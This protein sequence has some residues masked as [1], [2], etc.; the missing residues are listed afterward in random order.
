[1]GTFTKRPDA[2]QGTNERFDAR[3]KERVKSNLPVRLKY[4]MRED[5]RTGYL[6]VTFDEETVAILRRR[7][8][9]DESQPVFLRCR[10]VGQLLHVQND[11][12]GRIGYKLSGDR[13]LQVSS[14]ETANIPEPPDDAAHLAGVTADLLLSW[15]PEQSGMT[16]NIPR[17]LFERE[18]RGGTGQKLRARKKE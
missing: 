17:T 1:M 2:P 11:P 15:S 5:H 3:A 10:M 16:I 8:G 9:V 7:I 18:D 12:T 14:L 6:E 4:R 13:T